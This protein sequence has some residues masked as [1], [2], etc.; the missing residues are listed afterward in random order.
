MSKVEAGLQVGV[1]A[2]LTDNNEHHKARMKIEITG[3][4]DLKVFLERKKLE[5][6]STS[7]DNNIVIGDTLLTQPTNI[8]SA[9]RQPLEGG[10]QTKPAYQSEGNGA[11]KGLVE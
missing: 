8:R 3:I 1:G 6:A 7:R 5:R 2:R 11:A 4:S 10:S 9:A